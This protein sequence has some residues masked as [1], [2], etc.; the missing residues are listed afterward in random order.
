MRLH[1]AHARI[2]LKGD[3]QAGTDAVLH[4]L[5][6]C[7]VFQHAFLHG[8]HQYFQCVKIALAAHDD[9][10]MRA[11]IGYFGQHL[12]DLGGNTFTPRIMSI[13]SER[14]RMALWR[15]VVQPQ[16]GEGVKG[17][18]YPWCGS[19]AWS[20][21]VFFKRGKHQ[22]ALGALRQHLAGFGVYDFGIEIILV[23]VLAAFIYTF[24]GNA[25]TQN[26]AQATSSAWPLCR[27]ALQ[28]LAHGLGHALAAEHADFLRKADPPRPDA[29]RFRQDR[30]GVGGWPPAAWC[31]NPSL[32]LS[33]ARY[34]RWKWALWRRR[35]AQGRSAGRKRR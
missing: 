28:L 10:V 22:L 33:V 13:S 1:K 7:V 23:Y 26:L 4:F 31:R 17:R 8:L 11:D 12:L 34:F 3:A 9:F 30:G 21:P 16:A 32:S 27:A 24:A 6:A 25:G 15:T 19:A 18:L 5:K 20:S 14:P 35:G 29:R 2:Q